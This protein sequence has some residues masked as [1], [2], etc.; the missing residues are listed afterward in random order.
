MTPDDDSTRP[1]GRSDQELFRL[2]QRRAAELRFR[3]RATAF[4]GAALIL[5]VLGAAGMTGIGRDD[6][7][8]VRTA[9]GPATSSSPTP[10]LPGPSETASGSTSTTVP[11]VVVPPVDTTSRPTATSTSVP[12]SATTASSPSATP[13]TV[14]CRNSHD[15]ACGPFYFEPS[16]DPD[17]SMTV[18]VTVSPSTVKVGQEVVFH[19]VRRDADGVFGGRLATNFGDV[20]SH[21]DF[22]TEPCD[23]FGPWD[24]PPKNPSVATVTE[25][26]R[27]SYYAAGTFTATFS[28]GPEPPRCTDSRT[29]RGEN[30][31]ASSA[32][33]SV[34]VTVV[35]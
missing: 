13:T 23:R 9:A 20:Q 6:G 14:P 24:P 25:E 32:Q 26:I 31:Y 27:H 11:A 35:P 15:P 1:P 19:V 2:V 16:P 4:A 7:R 12:S 29:G 8:V 18:E 5:A 17:Q 28:Y 22:G 10:G 33:G 21:G 34:Q 30:A 3:R